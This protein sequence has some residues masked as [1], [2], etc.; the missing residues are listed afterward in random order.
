MMNQTKN[1]Q[2]ALDL[3]T[4]MAATYPVIIG[5]VYG[6]TARGEDTPFSDL[7]MWFV[8]EDGCPAQGQALLVQGNAVGYEVFREGELIELLTHPDRRWP[9]HAGVLDQ[10]RVLHG[11]PAR[12]RDWLRLATATPLERFHTYL[13]AHLPELVIESYGR[14]QSCALRSDWATARYAVTEVLFEMQTALCL[15]NKRWVTRDYDEG[16]RQVA[17]FPKVPAGYREIFPA[18]LVAREFGEMISL[19]DR[20]VDGF[21]HLLTEEGIVAKNYQTVEEIII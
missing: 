19:A 12:T 7:E 13:S 15:L 1:F 8:V 2:L 5:G 4:K 3:A 20:L 18:L 6:S 14:I 16:L 9:F 10:L 17:M 11:N 21:W